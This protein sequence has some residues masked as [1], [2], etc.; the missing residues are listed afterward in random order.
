MFWGQWLLEVGVHT[1]QEA[2][3]VGSPGGVVEVKAEIGSAPGK[4]SHDA[5]HD[6]LSLVRITATGRE[7]IAEQHVGADLP[8]R[9]SNGDHC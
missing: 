8:V 7:R 9:E 4:H 5:G 3:T 2:L 6:P 1:A